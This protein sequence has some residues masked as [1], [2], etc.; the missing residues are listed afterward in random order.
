MLGAE[1]MWNHEDGKWRVQLTADINSN[2]I[3]YRELAFWLNDNCDYTWT[4]AN[5]DS[6]EFAN[7]DDAMMFFLRFK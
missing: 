7:R 3:L 5:K 4:I 2:I 1:K 6:L